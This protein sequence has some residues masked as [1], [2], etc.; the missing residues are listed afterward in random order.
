MSRQCYKVMRR[1]HYTPYAKYTNGI[2]KII[3]HIGLRKLRTNFYR[4]N[5]IIRIQALY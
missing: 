1:S 5:M 3:R 4:V 2:Y